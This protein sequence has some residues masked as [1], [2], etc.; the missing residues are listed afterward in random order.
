MSGSSSGNL[1]S[2]LS[3][4][5]SRHLRFLGWKVDVEVEGTRRLRAI[6]CHYPRYVSKRTAV[7]CE[8]SE[9]RCNGEE[10]CCIVLFDSFIFFDAE[11]TLGFVSK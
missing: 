4:T 1:A 11:Y 5:V 10:D 2:D 6:K 3:H 9:E 7:F 8:V